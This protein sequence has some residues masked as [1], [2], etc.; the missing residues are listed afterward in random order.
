MPQ[1]HKPSE[2][3]FVNNEGADEPSS[4]GSLHTDAVEPLERLPRSCEISSAGRGYDVTSR[5][6]QAEFRRHLRHLHHNVLL[7]VH[8]LIA[9]PK[10]ERTL[11]RFVGAFMYRAQF[12]WLAESGLKPGA[13]SRNGLACAFCQALESYVP[14]NFHDVSP[15]LQDVPRRGRAIGPQAVFDSDWA[16]QLLVAARIALDEEFSLKQFDYSLHASGYDTTALTPND[17]MTH[18]ALALRGYWERYQQGLDAD[19]S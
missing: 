11:S 6:N 12:P 15:A 18:I 9:S 16:A 4:N 13:A 19:P 17:L 7:A 14:T 3:D 1:T 2:H 8:W 10:Y 5:L